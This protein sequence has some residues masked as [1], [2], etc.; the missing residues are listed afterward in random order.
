MVMVLHKLHFKEIYNFS[1][2]R[3]MENG[4]GITPS[5]L[6]EALPDY[7]PMMVMSTLGSMEGFYLTSSW[8]LNDEGRMALFYKPN[9]NSEWAALAERVMGL[10]PDEIG[11]DP[12]ARDQ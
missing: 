2:Q 7:D 8:K 9:T 10:D 4:K 1:R 12:M 11:F 5:E 6:K 3:Y